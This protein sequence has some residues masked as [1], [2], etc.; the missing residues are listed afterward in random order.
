MSG[1]SN[2]LIPG[3]SQFLP[4]IFLGVFLVYVYALYALCCSELARPGPARKNGPVQ[5]GPT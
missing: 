4:P 5:P 1:T 2:R 3:R